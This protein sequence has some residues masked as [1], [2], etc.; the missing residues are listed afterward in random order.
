MGSIKSIKTK[1]LWLKIAHPDSLVMNGG[2]RVAGN[3]NIHLYIYLYLFKADILLLISS[4]L[5]AILS[6][7]LSNMP[8]AYLICFNTFLIY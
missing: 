5:G 8:I 4:M 1:G 6:Y 2:H 7:V 3:A